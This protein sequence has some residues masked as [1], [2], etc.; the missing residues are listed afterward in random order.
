VIELLERFE[1]LF[2]I[3]V[4]WIIS[5]ILIIVLKMKRGNGLP[6]GSI[7]IETNSINNEIIIPGYNILLLIGMGSISFLTFFVIFLCIFDFWNIVASYIALDLPRWLNW[8]GIF[9]IWTQDCWGGLVISYNTNYTPAY[10]PMKKEY[11]LATGGPYKLVRHPMYIAKAFLVI[12]FFLATGIS[13][14]LIGLLT[15]LILSPQARR[16]EQAL[17]KKFGR[18]YEEYCKKTG[19]FFPKIKRS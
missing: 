10:K 14:T 13:F 1:L 2:S 18:T 7:F 4:G 16:E 9:G 19:R 11:I 8:I 17:L 15:W 12:F 3:I 5:I 6:N